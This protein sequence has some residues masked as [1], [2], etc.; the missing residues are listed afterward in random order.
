MAAT[1]KKLGWH[2]FPGPAA[3][4]SQGYDD[5]PGCMYHGFCSRG[6]CPIH[7]KNSTAV[8]TIPKAV[9]TGR[10]KVVTLATTT[11]VAVDQKSG[12]ATGVNYVKGEDL[13]SRSKRLMS[14]ANLTGRLS[15]WRGSSVVASVS[16]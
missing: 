9:A 12:R 1:A 7:A 4:N 6:G 3:I 13:V 8:S 2:P 15:P 5:R 14:E 11:G 10:L 16:P